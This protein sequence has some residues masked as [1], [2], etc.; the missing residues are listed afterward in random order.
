MTR[1]GKPIDR[2][3]ISNFDFMRGVAGS[4]VLQAKVGDMCDIVVQESEIPAKPEY[5]LLED[6][7]FVGPAI[8]TRTVSFGS[9]KHMDF[10]L[11]Y[12]LENKAKQFID[13][14]W[15]RGVI[16]K[17][18]RRSDGHLWVFV[19]FPGEKGYYDVDLDDGKVYEALTSLMYF[20]LW[21][22]THFSAPV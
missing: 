6:S 18:E 3:V 11:C 1:D 13:W 4:S 20:A 10:A 16:K 22:L 5:V 8:N 2:A 19:K 21:C 14:Q 15:F 7:L 9:L 17:V 12:R